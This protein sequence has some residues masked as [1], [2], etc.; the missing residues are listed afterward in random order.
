MHSPS[1]HR[2][3]TPML[4]TPLPKK[5]KNKILCLHL[6]FRQ[7]HSSTLFL[8]R[9]GTKK[10]FLLLQKYSFLFEKIK[11]LFQHI[12]L[13]KKT[14]ILLPSFQKVTMELVNDKR[15]IQAN[16]NIQFS[17]GDMLFSSKTIPNESW[18]RV[19]K[20][21]QVSFVFVIGQKGFF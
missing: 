20:W 9:K 21:I 18:M 17:K 4:P 14:K 5:A 2:S 12:Q 11:T 7:E 1:R 6:S 13:S 16:Q 19:S 10:D 3:N 8:S 15:K